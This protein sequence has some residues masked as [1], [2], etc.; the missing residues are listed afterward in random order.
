MNTRP[1]LQPRDGSRPTFDVPAGA[2][3]AHLHVFDARCAE[4]CGARLTLTPARATARDD[5]RVQQRL[6]MR[7]AALV[8]PRDDGTDNSVT[9]DAIAQ[10]GR[11]DTRGVAVLT[12]EVDDATRVRLH[13]GGK[14]RLNA[15]SFTPAPDTRQQFGQFIGS[16]IAKWSQVV[17]TARIAPQ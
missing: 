5:P 11:C 15:M 17:T 1:D 12:P 2:C 6:G 4:V 13:Q 10:L 7:R 16:E 8:Q 14:E 9:L 3:D